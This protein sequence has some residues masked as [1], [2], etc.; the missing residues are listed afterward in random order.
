LLPKV[1]KLVEDGNQD[2][3]EKALGILAKVKMNYGDCKFK[4]FK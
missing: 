1:K 3:R 2:I 4:I